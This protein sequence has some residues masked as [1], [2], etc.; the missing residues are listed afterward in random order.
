M[1]ANTLPD[2]GARYTAD[3]LSALS[4][5]PRRTIRYYIQ[6]G[7]V[8]RPIG[9]TRAAHY[10]WKHL[11]QLLRIREYTEAGLSLERIGQVLAA[12]AQAPAVPQ[13]PP[14]PGSIVVQSH[15][16]IAPGVQLVI[17][18]AQSRLSGEALRELVRTVVA[19]CRGDRTDEP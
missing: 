18:P 19:A 12:E 8:D 1:E 10:T 13:L 7:L 17:D 11:G 2:A 9:E 3:E 15:I 14:A 5:T 6:L 16:H 4:G